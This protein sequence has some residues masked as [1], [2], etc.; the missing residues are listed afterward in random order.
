MKLL[1]ENTVQMTTK[2]TGKTVN[3]PITELT[4]FGFSQE[5]IKSVQNMY[6]FGNNKPSILQTAV[7]MLPGIFGA[8]GG[9]T[10]FAAIPI[11]GVG[12]GAGAAA[13]YAGGKA[14]QDILRPMVGTR[15]QPATNPIQAM[16]K[17]GQAGGEALGFGVK[18][19]AADLIYRTLVTDDTAN[20]MANKT[21][22]LAKE[23]A[24]IKISPDTLENRIRTEI[25][26]KYGMGAN[27]Y[28]AQAM[29]DIVDPNL[30]TTAEESYY[31]P[32]SLLNMRRSVYSL[33]YSAETSSLQRWV[34]QDI[35]RIAGEEFHAAVPQAQLYDTAYHYIKGSQGLTK[36]VA[37]YSLR[38]AVRYTLIYPMLHNLLS[39]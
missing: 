4:K 27:K 10:G 2:D 5:G 21:T 30:V 1:N 9:I 22:S 34:N 33:G 7:E 38:A 28:I 8:V 13:G 31:N 23:N 25:P 19:G 11:P 6:K 26:A 39:Q 17:V 36:M 12:A 16:G 32:E 24:N 37:G 20:M 29:N 35:A 15:T 3:L 18:V 14:A